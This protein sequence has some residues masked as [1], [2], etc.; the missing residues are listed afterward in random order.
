MSSSLSASKSEPLRLELLVD[1]PEALRARLYPDGLLGGL[2]L[3]GPLPGTLGQRCEVRVQVAGLAERHFTVQGLLAWARHQYSVSMPPSFGVAFVREDAGARARLVGYAN[4]A[5][6]PEAARGAQR[7]E[8]QIAATL[9]HE[10]KSRAEV[11]SNVSE[12]GVFVQTRLLLPPG[13]HVQLA[14]RPPGSLLKA[15][16]NGLVA[17]VRSQGEA[18]GFGVAFN[19]RD[20][21]QALRLRRLVARLNKRAQRRR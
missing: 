3:S 21:R 15:R 9:E 16:F 2:I 18:P 13:S 17:W 6:E 11:L 14:F 20:Q 10:G 5:V 12:G 4:Q 1:G 19:L 8:I 7:L